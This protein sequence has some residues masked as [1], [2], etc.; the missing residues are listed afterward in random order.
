MGISI[1][2]PL[3]S[4]TAYTPQV[5]SLEY[6][7]SKYQYPGERYLLHKLTLRLTTNREPG[8]YTLLISNGGV[9]PKVMFIVLPSG[10]LTCCLVSKA[11]DSPRSLE[12]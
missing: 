11:L 8:T 4:E 1:C 5:G 10:A 2:P 9:P 6:S 7:R 12:K 3:W